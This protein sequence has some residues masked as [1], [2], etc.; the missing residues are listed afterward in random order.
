MDKKES[1]MELEIIRGEQ[2]IIQEYFEDVFD[3]D[4]NEIDKDDF[5]ELEYMIYGTIQRTLPLKGFSNRFWGIAIKH[6]LQSLYLK[7]YQAKKID[8]EE[9]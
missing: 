9:L 8:E 3:Y 7:A 5:D 4:K 6:D 1:G 2:Q